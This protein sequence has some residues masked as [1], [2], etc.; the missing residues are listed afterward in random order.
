[1]IPVHP[2][3]WSYTV[4][5]LLEKLY[6]IME[7]NHADGSGIPVRKSFN[8][9][10]SETTNYFNRDTCSLCI[11]CTGNFVTGIKRCRFHSLLQAKYV[12]TATRQQEGTSFMQTF[13]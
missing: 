3:N 7:M 2:D 13:T 8:A 9:N 1:V 10:T 11:K 5:D 12:K 6:V 4:P